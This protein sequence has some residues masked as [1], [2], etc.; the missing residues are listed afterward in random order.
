MP[1]YSEEIKSKLNILN[2]GFGSLGTAVYV[3][4]TIGCLKATKVLSLT[5][6]KRMVLSVSMLINGLCLFAFA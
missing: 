2:F 3:G 6:S 1:S 4:V 5:G